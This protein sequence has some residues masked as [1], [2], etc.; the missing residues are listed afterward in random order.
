MCQYTGHNTQTEINL[1]DYSNSCTSTCEL[2]LELTFLTLRS[3]GILWKKVGVSVEFVDQICKE[4]EEPAK[5][6][7]WIAFQLVQGNVIWV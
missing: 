2:A 3:E 1:R 4:I 7:E 5:T 6:C